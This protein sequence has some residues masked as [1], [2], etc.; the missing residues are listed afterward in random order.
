MPIKTGEIRGLTLYQPY[1]SAIIFGPKR[2]ENRPRNMAHVP[3][4]GFWIAVQAALKMAHQSD[5]LKMRNLGWMEC[6][7]ETALPT[8]C[9]IGLA[10][11]SKNIPYA[12]PAG[13][14]LHDDP[15]AFGPWCMII[16]RVIPLPNPVIVSGKQGLWRLFVSDERRLRSLIPGE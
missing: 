14:A 11:V 9:I 16:D 12:S 10:H 13:W 7:D 15:W 3:P 1:A 8:G 4:G 6:P 2:V 5:V